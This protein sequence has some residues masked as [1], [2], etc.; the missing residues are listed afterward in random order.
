MNP[1]M[2]QK[3]THRQ[4]EQICGCQGER[5][6]EWDGVGVCEFE[7]GRCKLSDLER[8]S[9]EVL[10]CSTGNHIQSLGIDHDGK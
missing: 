7:V 8:K 2:K 6:R 3:Q 1:S 4:R 10:L 5:G 9:N